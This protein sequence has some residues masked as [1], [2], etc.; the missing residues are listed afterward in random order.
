MIDFIYKEGKERS[1]F[2]YHRIKEM[3]E[4]DV[5]WIWPPAILE[6]KRLGDGVL[7]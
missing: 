6:A 1:S 7:S 2:V 5:L 3:K 4:L